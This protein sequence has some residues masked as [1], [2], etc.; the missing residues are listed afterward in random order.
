MAL[1]YSPSEPLGVASSLS[2]C[3]FQ[4]R[5]AEVPP[6]RQGSVAHGDLSF[7]QLSS[8][9][10]RLLSRRGQGQNLNLQSM[11]M[12]LVYEPQS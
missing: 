10:P 7:H 8:R 2:P 1:L 9:E 3:L 6:S 11:L 5:V 4:S 12:H